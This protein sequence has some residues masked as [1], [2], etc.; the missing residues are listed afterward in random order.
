MNSK[1][2]RRSLLRGAAAMAAPAAFPQPPTELRKIRVA[3]I[4][5]GGRGTV[6]LRGSLS[7]PAVEV[8][9][10][11]DILPEAANRGVDLVQTRLGTRPATY[12]EGP[13]DYKRLL[14]RD[15]VD[16]VFVT[17]PAV[18][19]GPM[20]ADSL[21]AGKWVFSEVPACHSLEEGWELVR[22]A[23]ESGAGYFLAENY[24]FTRHNLMALNMVDQGVFGAVTFAEC[25]YI[26]NTRD[27]QFNADGSLTWRGEENSDPKFRGNTYPTHS[28]GPASMAL[29]INHGDRFTTCISMMTP[30]RG[31]HEYASRRFGAQSGP[32][33]LKTW[34]G[35]NSLTL[36][37]TESGAVVYLRFDNASPRPHRM[38]FYTLQGSKASFDDLAGIY[39][40]YQSRNWEPFSDY[41]SRFDH[42]YWTRNA[43]AARTAGHSGGDYFTVQHFI[44]SIRE[45]RMPGIDVYD[46][47]TWSA[48]TPLSARSIA[49]NSTRQSFPDYTRGRWKT[50]KRFDWAAHG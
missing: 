16:A 3:V 6:M 48:L 19:H 32:A 28:L 50:A 24:C 38:G 12:T 49:E 31:F 9:A 13:T 43:E 33:R 14:Q 25:G 29:S 34:N 18:W 4:G 8:A 45:R 23:E 36:L 5:V 15:D 37:R 39:I 26:H 35:D 10:L 1:T 44:R 21:R 40:D 2:T 20:A 22:A 30:A 7:T 27:L 46:A 17:T 11:C 47:V 41:Y 42:P